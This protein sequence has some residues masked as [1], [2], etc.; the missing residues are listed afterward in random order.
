[1]LILS[2]HFK[3]TKMTM[4]KTATTKTTMTKAA[5]VKTTMTIITKTTMVNRKTANKCFFLQFDLSDKSS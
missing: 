5:N 3:K 4:A 2:A 1:M